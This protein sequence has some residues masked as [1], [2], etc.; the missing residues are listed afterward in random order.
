MNN[1]TK[2]IELETLPPDDKLVKYANQTGLEKTAASTLAE[3]F[4]PIF[5]KARA[6]IDDAR[7]V[8]ES[9]KDATCVKEIKKSRAC[10]LALRA[11]RLESEATRK[12]QKEHA[13]RRG[14]VS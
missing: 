13:L 3:A 12:K 8:A 10:R 5:V 4:K 1:E 11:V 6:A 2:T 9:V 14:R 7:G